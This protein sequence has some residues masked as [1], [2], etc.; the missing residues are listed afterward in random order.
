MSPGFVEGNDMRLHAEI[1]NRII[2]ELERGTVPWVKPWAVPLPYNVATQHRYSGVNVLL[3]W[4]APYQRP[5]W[6]TFRQ[7]TLLGGRVKKGEH[8]TPIVYVSTVT[9]T[10]G[11]EEKEISFL[12]RYYVFNVEQVEG[13]PQNLYAP[14][15]L[16]TPSGIE[17]FFAEI[18]ADVR[19]GGASAYYEPIEDYIQL[20]R[21]EYY[22]GLEL[23]HATRLHETVHWTGHPTRLERQFGE[24]FGDSAYAFEELVAELGAAF[25]SAELGLPTELHHAAY[26]GSWVQLLR[27]H[28]RAILS[29]A[30][31]ASSAAEYL[32]GTAHV[33]DVPAVAA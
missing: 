17:E 2:A 7:A 24:R 32:K 30:S 1:T 11:D 25:L 23:Y 10:E 9:K 20:P 8:A 33:G 21:P 22:L 4:D 13:L 18:S 31:H 3:L 6:L 27:D 14:A 26:I 29:A 12:R 5:A 15:T 19:H 16:S 28:N